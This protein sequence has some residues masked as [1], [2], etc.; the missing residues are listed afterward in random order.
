[1]LR[2]YFA[3][4]A[5]N[6]FKDCLQFWVISFRIAF[7]LG[8]SVTFP[9]KHIDDFFEVLKKT[10]TT[11]RSVLRRCPAR[12]LGQIWALQS[13]LRRCPARPLGQI[14]A[15]RSVLRSCPARPPLNIF[16]KEDLLKIYF[17]VISKRYISNEYD[18]VRDFNTHDV[19]TNWTLRKQNLQ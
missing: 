9:P 14:W 18:I 16:Y 19:L 7:C 12:P 4:S 1:M 17:F 13:V 15:L 2:F 5:E 3:R 11:A 6:F 10:T 8:F